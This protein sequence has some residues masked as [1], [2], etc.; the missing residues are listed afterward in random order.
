MSE[1]FRDSAVAHL[2]AS[3]QTI[4]IPAT[5]QTNDAAILQYCVFFGSADGTCNITTPSGWTLIDGEQDIHITV[6]WF[7]KVIGVS[8][9]GST[10]TLAYTGTTGVKA[11]AVMTV[12]AG[13]DTTDPVAEFTVIHDT[14]TANAHVFGDVT[15]LNNGEMVV[16]FLAERVAVAATSFSV[17]SGA[18]IRASD[19]LG[20]G[21]NVDGAAVDTGSPV[22]ASGT[23]SGGWTITSSG[24]SSGHVYMITIGLKPLVVAQTVLP[25]SDILTTSWTKIGAPSTFAGV[26]SDSSD[27]TYGE[28]AASPTSLS[29]EVKLATAPAALQSLTFRLRMTGGAS[30]GSAVISLVQNTT[31]LQSATVSLTSSFAD[32]VLALTGGGV[33]GQTDLTNLRARAVVTAS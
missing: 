4:T 11:S 20:T 25:A 7:K 27:A 14:A 30:S 5:A 12:H 1:S 8:D 18:V 26:T 19:L 15:T 29:F 6:A 3:G 23:S 13:C 10:V 16:G 31:I 2:S 22:S 33:S 21:G 17:S 9:P 28:S 32:Y 24:T